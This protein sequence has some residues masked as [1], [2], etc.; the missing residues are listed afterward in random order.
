M[1]LVFRPSEEAA[2][3]ARTALGRDEKPVIWLQEG[4]RADDVAKRAREEGVT[5]IQDLCAF[6]VH[7]ALEE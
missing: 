2:E 1:V 5:V 6:K 4:I 7:K 3:I